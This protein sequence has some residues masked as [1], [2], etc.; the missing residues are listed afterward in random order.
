[1]QEGDLINSA[2]AEYNASVAETKR[3]MEEREPLTKRG[4]A[5]AF[6]RRQAG[7]LRQLKAAKLKAKVAKARKDKVKVFFFFVWPHRC[8]PHVVLSTEHAF[9]TRKVDHVVFTCCGLSQERFDK[10]KA[11]FDEAKKYNERIVSETKKLEA[12]ESKEEYADNL[13]RLKEVSVAFFL[14]TQSMCPVVTQSV[15]A[16]HLAS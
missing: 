6:K 9:L 15:V 7:I 13:A 12:L 3:L 5:A 1:M 11:M 16:L 8:C 10:V 4:R 2:T 14:C